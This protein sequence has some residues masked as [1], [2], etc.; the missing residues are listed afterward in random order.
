M[1]LLKEKA[2]IKTEID[3][4]EDIHVVKAIKNILAIGKT[5]QYENS[6]HPMSLSLFYERNELSQKAIKENHLID[7]QEVKA[8]FS[9]KNAQK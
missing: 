4:I 2:F 9:K 1:D 3:K 7:H 6:L 8:Y 5:K